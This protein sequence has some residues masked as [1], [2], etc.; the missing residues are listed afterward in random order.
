MKTT[1]DKFWLD[2]ALPP[3]I[4]ATQRLVALHAGKDRARQAD[5]LI[6]RL[7]EDGAITLDG[8][9]STLVDAAAKAHRQRQTTVRAHARKL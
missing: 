2:Q 7:A 3:A 6:E 9:R 1:N 5:W 4:A 8:L